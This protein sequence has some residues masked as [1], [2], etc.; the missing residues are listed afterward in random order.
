MGLS[1]RGLTQRY[2][3]MSKP[4]ITSQLAAIQKQRDLL[5]KK[6]SAL[7]AELHGKVLT[8]IIKM[9]QDAGLT[10]AEITHAYESQRTK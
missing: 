3:D 10:S 6:E 5:A 7:K 9:A 4:S 8:Q 2:R 1:F